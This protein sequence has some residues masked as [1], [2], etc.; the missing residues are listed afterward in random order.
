M[1]IIYY[2]CILYI[3]Y[4]LYVLYIL[5]KCCITYTLYV[6]IYIIYV[7]FIFVYI[8]TFLYMKNIHTSLCCA[9]TINTKSKWLACLFLGYFS[10]PHFFES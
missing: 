9:K 6:Y 8:Y 10:C 4:L 3:L 2:I 7:L 1:Y 5:Y